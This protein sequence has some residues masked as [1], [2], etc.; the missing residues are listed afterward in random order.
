MNNVHCAAFLIYFFAT[1]L[2]AV[3]IGAIPKNDRILQ[4]VVASMIFRNLRQLFVNP[5]KNNIS[6]L[7]LIS[8][9]KNCHFV[10]SWSIASSYMFFSRH[11]FCIH[12]NLVCIIW[13]HVIG[14]SKVRSIHYYHYRL[15]IFVG[16]GVDHLGTEV[17]SK[18]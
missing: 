15:N 14:V 9:Y 3:F 5:L 10:Y 4:G 7:E 18:L 2:D 8:N 16:I 17:G 11:L 13:H 6:R 1:D 12:N